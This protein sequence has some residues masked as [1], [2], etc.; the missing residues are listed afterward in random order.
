MTS[1]GRH[2][3]WIGADTRVFAEVFVQPLGAGRVT[4][5]HYTRCTI[6]TRRRH[7]RH[8]HTGILVHTKHRPVL[9]DDS[10]HIN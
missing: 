8:C 5:L 4:W 1:T 3:V 7:R 6:K 9:S 10:L 2:V